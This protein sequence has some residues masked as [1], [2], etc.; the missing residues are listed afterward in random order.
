MTRAL[1]LTF[2]ASL[3][4]CLGP[5]RARADSGFIDVWTNG[6]D[7]PQIVFPNWKAIYAGSFGVWI[8]PTADAC[9]GA[10]EIIKGLTVANFGTAGPGDISAV[11]VKMSCGA[12]SSALLTMTYAGTYTEDAGP[13]NAWTWAG[14]SPDFS[15]CADL[16]GAPYLC[17][18]FF[19]IDVYVDVAPCPANMST[20]SVG[21]PTR[22][23]AT[24]LWGGSIADNNTYPAPNYDVTAGSALIAYTF[25]T[26]S[27]TTVAP[28]DTITYT[29]YYGKPGTS[30]LA[31]IVIT[32]TQPPYTH[33]VSGSAVP[34]PDLTWDPD[35]GPPMRLRWTI[36]PVPANLP[37]WGPTNEIHFS[38]SVD[39]GNGELFE[40]GSG[41]VAAPEGQRLNNSADVEFDGTTCPVNVMS[42]PPV[43]TVVKRFIFWI[44]GDND[45][46]FSPTYGQPP[47][48]M[49]YSIFIKN[50]SP[51][52]TWWDVRLWDT[53][54]PD[55]DV[56][57]PNYGFYDPCT[58]WTMT[59]S[60][61]SAA[62]PGR[63]T[64]GGKTLLTWRLDMPPGLTLAIQWKSRVSAT[65]QAK[66]TVINTLSVLEY[67]KTGIVGGT[68]NSG[69]PRNFTHL[70]PIV[71]PTMYTSYV[72]Y[73][74]G[75]SCCP[76]YLLDFF[77]LN[78]KTQ[79]ELR[80]L[81]Y[82]GA[83]WATTGGASASIGTLIGDCLGGFPLGGIAGCK[84][85]R[86]PAKFDA[87]MAAIGD[88]T[89][90]CP[91]AFPFNYIFK[92]TSNS[93]TLWQVL[94]HIISHDEDNHTYAPATTLSY[95]GLM[96]YM[97]KRD[98]VPGDPPDPGNGDN[99]SLINTSI[100]PYG[101]Y[102]PTLDT[103]VYEF[104]FNYATLQW[105]LW[106]TYDIAPESQAFDWNTFHPIEGA[107]RTVSS[108]GQLIVNQGML[109]IQSIA[110]GAS[111]N[112][113]AYMP[114]RETGNTV[115]LPGQTAN[116]YGIVHG[117]SIGS[118]V[119]IGNLGAVDAVYRIW[120]YVPDNLIVPAK[121]PPWLGGTSGT[122]ALKATHTVPAGLAT[123][124]NPRAY[125]QD[126]AMFDQSNTIELSKIELL[127][128]GPIQVLHGMRVYEL[129]AGGSVMHPAD[130]KQTGIEYWLHQAAGGGKGCSS[131][132]YYIN[133]F[134]PKTGMAVNMISEDGFSATYTTTGP[135][136]CIAFTPLSDAATFR[137]WKITVLPNPAQGNV[138]CQFID[139]TASEK[140]WTAPFLQEG[141]HYEFIAPPT[142]F[143][144][145]SFWMTIIV[146]D[147][148][149][150][151]KLDYCG[152]TSFT[153]TDPAA[154]IESTAMDVYN[155]TWSSATCNNNGAL[156]DENGIRIFVNVTL[157]TLGMQTI[158]GQDTTDGSINGLTAI[159]VVATD[160]KLTKV[161]VLSIAASG[162]T[163]QFRVC[164]SNYS[165][166]SA[167][168]FVITDAVPMG[169]VYVPEAMTAMDCGNT[170]GQPLTVAYSTATSAGVPA[171]ASFTN[172]APIAGTRWL[173]WTLP[174][175][176][177]NT[178]G[179]ACYRVTVN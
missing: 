52:K 145:Q 4:A 150:T 72:G 65:A 91:A 55:L 154:K 48:E 90:F 85:E 69:Q 47:D 106:R 138:V 178:T 124:G 165:S 97:W 175:A 109:T 59:P 74:A 95:T 158:V 164:W 136:Q 166:A 44:L 179:C 96:H 73:G 157:T 112:F 137:N 6:Q 176:G 64:S 147:V 114:T 51:T 139:C 110:G 86:I 174:Y 107:Y 41:D 171:A 119:V 140:G 54:P 66:G 105:D 168:T 46:L 78:K 135:D 49:T 162:D 149:G 10:T 125:S 161:P 89:G 160:I 81:F 102:D 121:F 82:V 94:T 116:F 170:K 151:T 120:R 80:A 132:Q 35:L 3:S 61:C 118:K 50:V 26:S 133:V 40:P 163:V 130:G 43:S 113:A 17:G 76:G 19:T 167:F 32:D 16:C 79:F 12:T 21:F 14:S 129:W 36:N 5:Q 11:T 173:R 68:G 24:P 131:E 45:V 71:L 62:T 63:T 123:A 152:T 38:L 39:W 23:I 15:S 127:T 56:W 92:V 31:D 34:A 18:A 57:G 156:P 108:Q 155:F 53:V 2:L 29:V 111:D 75:S 99:L 7:P 88:C 122:W 134:C 177:V 117:A 84:V 126:G 83:G 169:T 128:G 101:V 87:G 159:L 58:G 146:K 143:I 28:G 172:G 9:G 103:T 27:D 1:L 98:G 8:C 30:P 33:Y 115:S 148:G 141:V 77:P 37:Q 104:V 100:N 93:P 60:G 22:W 142:V 42:N 13:L 25:K 20:L 153:S 144:G 67:G 70:A